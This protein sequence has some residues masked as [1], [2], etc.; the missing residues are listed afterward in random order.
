MGHVG[1]GDPA[2]L[3]G[4][5][6]VRVLRGSHS[7]CS[8]QCHAYQDGDDRLRGRQCVL[9]WCVMRDG[10]MITGAGAL[11]LSDDSRRLPRSLYRIFGGRQA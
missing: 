11:R 1:A 4:L 8:R 6:L 5:F 2:L 7:A 9:A 3:D 10:L